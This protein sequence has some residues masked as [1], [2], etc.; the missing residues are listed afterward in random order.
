MA[1]SLFH[2]KKFKYHLTLE[3]S[4]HPIF[5]GSTMSTKTRGSWVQS[6]NEELCDFPIENLPF[7]SFIKRDEIN[8]SPCIGV[9]IGNQ[10][11][12][13]TALAN[14]QL[15]SSPLIT[16]LIE[17]LL[18]LF[19]GQHL[20]AYM[21]RSSKDHQLFRIF[22]I[23]CLSVNS[24]LQSQLNPHLI[25]QDEVTMLRPCAIQDY[26]DFYASIHHATTVGAMFRPDQPLMPNYKWIP[27][28][29]HGRAS[30]IVPS[31]TPIRRPVGQT[32]G[33]GNQPPFVQPSRRLDYELEMGVFIGAGN[34]MGQTIAMANSKEHFFGL[35]LLND[36]SARDIQ[37]WEYQPLGPFLAKNFASTISPWIV[38]REALEP[39]AR[40]FTRVESDPQPLDYLSD[41]TTLAQGAYDIR[42]QTWLETQ[43]M[44]EQQLG[45]VKL[46]E[47]NFQEAMYWSLFQLI[48]HHASNGC[49]LNPGDLLG[50]GTMSGP[51]KDQAGSLLELSEGGKTPVPLPNGETRTFLENGDT[52]IL[53]AF[54][55]R[56]GYPRIGFGQCSGTITA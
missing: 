29:Y 32:K 24:P 51:Q 6:A 43:Q 7:G 31:G 12:N 20:N 9:A 3:I 16:P 27:I 26:S 13:L 38:T 19:K 17:E 53:K 44:R 11:L 41:A 15:Q 34:A 8:P 21:A 23:Q 49:N 35:C 2:I 39:F 37:G 52:I 10:V 46:M 33:S 48:T 47:S 28:G 30:S 45:P 18:N 54:C 36:W 40:E 42:L 55:E 5:R 25:A 4:K 14:A 1:A 50:T 56:D 22:L